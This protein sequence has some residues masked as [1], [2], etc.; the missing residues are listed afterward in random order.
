MLKRPVKHYT[1]EPT[2]KPKVF[3]D[4]SVLLSALFSSRGGSFYILTQL[5]NILEL[6][7]N[8]YVLAETLEVLDRKFSHKSNLKNTFFLLL[9]TGKVTIITNPGSKDLK[10]I[11]KIVNEEDAPILASAILESDYL[12]T[13]DQDFLEESVKKFAQ[14]K[15]IQIVTPGELINYLRGK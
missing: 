9:G 14:K 2:K 7:I 12:A 11:E 6:Q 15:N 4:S 3:L 8:E 13:L 5:K 10:N 1:K